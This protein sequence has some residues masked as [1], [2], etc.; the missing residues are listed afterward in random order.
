[1]QSQENNLDMTTLDTRH[2]TSLIGKPST[3]ETWLL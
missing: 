3:T 2:T 1:M